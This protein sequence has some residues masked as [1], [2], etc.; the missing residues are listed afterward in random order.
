MDDKKLSKHADIGYS[1]E[2]LAVRKINVRITLDHRISIGILEDLD[3]EYF[4]KT[5]LFDICCS[6]AKTF[7]MSSPIQQFM[8]PSSRERIAPCR[9]GMCASRSPLEQS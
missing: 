1:F 9:V 6:S 7:G 8:A 2:D 3:L 5:P 4:P